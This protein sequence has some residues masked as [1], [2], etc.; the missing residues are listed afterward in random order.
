MLSKIIF[1][2]SSCSFIAS[3]IF[4]KKEKKYGSIFNNL[5]NI[6]IIDFDNIIDYN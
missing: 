2:S 5:E 3:V 6:Q 4:W 1:F